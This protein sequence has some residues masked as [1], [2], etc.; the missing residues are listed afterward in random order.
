MT[1]QALAMIGKACACLCIEIKCREAV[2]L[3]F[4]AFFCEAHHGCHAAGVPQI[5]EQ[6]TYQHVF[7]VMSER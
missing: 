5:L 4:A 3:Q 1:A 2:L 6:A 7:L